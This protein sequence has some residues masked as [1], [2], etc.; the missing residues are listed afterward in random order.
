MTLQAGCRF[1][2]APRFHLTVDWPERLLLGV[3]WEETNGGFFPRASWRPP[4]ADELTI[5]C[6]PVAGV[7]TPPPVPRSR[8]RSTDPG[9][10]PRSLDKLDDAV[11]LFKLP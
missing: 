9:H 7:G 11:C 3:G 8:G 10:R 4:S 1:V 2:V 6:D 5:L